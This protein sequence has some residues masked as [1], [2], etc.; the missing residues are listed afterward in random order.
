M[1]DNSATYGHVTTPGPTSV[2]QSS[3]SQEWLQLLPNSCLIPAAPHRDHF[4]SLLK[5][6]PLLRAQPG[7]G[8]AAHDSLA[9]P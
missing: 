9:V 7:F 5:K 2:R 8:P 6:T 4:F 3:P 1:K